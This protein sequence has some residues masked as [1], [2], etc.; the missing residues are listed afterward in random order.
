MVPAGVSET[1]V[2]T[3]PGNR[4]TR[5]GGV[6]HL[7]ALAEELAAEA[8]RS[9]SAR[10]G[11]TLVAVGPLRS[12][13]IALAAGADLAEHENPGAATLQVLAG[14]CRLVAGDD[15][16]DLEAGALVQIPDRRHAVTTDEGCVLL[17]TVGLS[18]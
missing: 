9:A 1:V 15:V 8:T 14:A 2:V 11:R 5:H 3:D 16:V 10:S 6:Q 13:A 18:T 4:G 17:L 12:T 7:T